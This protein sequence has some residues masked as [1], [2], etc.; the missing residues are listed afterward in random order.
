MTSGKVVGLA[1][2]SAAVLVAIGLFTRSWQPIADDT[3]IFVHT[4][5]GAYATAACI[6]NGTVDRDYVRNPIMILDG[7]TE[8]ILL[9]GVVIRPYGDIRRNREN[10]ATLTPDDACRNANGFIVE[11][12]LLTALFH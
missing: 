7:P 2:A 5:S 9:D 6:A 3:P 12:T 8:A 1:L 11:R 10:E 4:P